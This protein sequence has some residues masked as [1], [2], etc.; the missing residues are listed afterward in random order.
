V[1]EDRGI[2][3]LYPAQ[4]TRPTPAR[5]P[6][7]GDRARS[8]HI[9]QAVFVW[10]DLGEPWSV[11]EELDASLRSARAGGYAGIRETGFQRPHFF[12]FYGREAR[13]LIE[14]I[15]PLI[16]KEGRSDRAPHSTRRRGRRAAGA[17]RDPTARINEP[18]RRITRRDV[19]R[20]MK[21]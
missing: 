19:Q 17:H 7:E 8:D 11:L 9:R 18:G 15:R 10:I 13:R 1:I 4:P 16:E 5:A 3:V 6:D 12:E 14:L 21:L 20:A 2:A